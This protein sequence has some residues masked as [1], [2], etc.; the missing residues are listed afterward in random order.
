MFTNQGVISFPMVAL[1]CSQMQWHWREIK[2]FSVE[3]DRKGEDYLEKGKVELHFANHSLG[4]YQEGTLWQRPKA[5]IQEMDIWP[6]RGSQSRSQALAPA[7][8]AANSTATT[9]DQRTEKHWFL[10]SSLRTGNCMID[11]HSPK[12]VLGICM[13]S[14]EFQTLQ[15]DKGKVMWIACACEFALTVKIEL[16]KNVWFGARCGST[17]I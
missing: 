2:I 13:T 8:V 12:A 9:S 5:L 11:V 10:L 14:F 3:T 1:F 4:T 17:C 7:L 15:G 6:W 16:L